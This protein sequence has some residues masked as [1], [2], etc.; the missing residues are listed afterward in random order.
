MPG[1]GGFET[2]AA[3]T[4]D[5]LLR[6]TPVPGLTTSGAPHDVGRAYDAHANSHLRRPISCETSSS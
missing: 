4:A 5:P 1:L 3:I 6:A 2:L